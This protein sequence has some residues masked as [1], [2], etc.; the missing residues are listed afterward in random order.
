MQSNIETRERDGKEKREENKN[1]MPSGM[2]RKSLH[3]NTSFSTVDK[4]SIYSSTEN[5]LS[6][7]WWKSQLI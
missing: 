4:R 2:Q 5:N 3:P 6:K 7:V 1:R